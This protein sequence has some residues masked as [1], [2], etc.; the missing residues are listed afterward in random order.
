MENDGSAERRRFVRKVIELPVS[1]ESGGWLTRI[2]ISGKTVNI[3]QGGVCISFTNKHSPKGIVRLKI[4]DFSSGTE[5][6]A[7]GKIAWCRTLESGE[8]SM[9]IDFTKV[10]WTKLQELISQL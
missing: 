10:A 8:G 5:I 9:G 6:D 2:K 1:C 3:S 7:E 4:T